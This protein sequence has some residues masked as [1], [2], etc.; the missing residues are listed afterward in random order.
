[1]ARVPFGKRLL[2]GS[3]TLQLPIQLNTVTVTWFST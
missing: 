2:V 3:H 1:M